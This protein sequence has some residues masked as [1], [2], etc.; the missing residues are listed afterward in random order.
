MAELMVDFITSL[1]GFGA[2]EGWPGLWGMGGPEYLAWLDE[3]SRIAYTTLMGATTYRMFVGFAESGAD[4]LDDL[5]ARPKFVFSRTLRAPL[6]WENSTLIDRDAVEAVRELKQRSETPLRTIGSLS[7]CRALLEAGLVDRYRVVVFP[8]VNG[9]S[10]RDR[11]Y[12]GWPDVALE[13]VDHRTF[14]GRLQLLEFAPTVLDGPPAE[15]A[16]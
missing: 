15:P 4:F 16:P 14:D 6:A 3:E 8:V 9:A 10:G 1:D 13:T 11:I 2:A 7:L 5:T 12:D